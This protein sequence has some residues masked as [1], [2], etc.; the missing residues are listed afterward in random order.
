MRIAYVLT[1]MLVGCSASSTP[2]PSA[3][4]PTLVEA[5]PRYA[6]TRPRIVAHRGASREA[7]ENT[8]AAFRAAWALGVE[9][10]ELDVRV[11]RDGAVVVIHDATT[12]RIGGVDR[13]VADQTLAELRAMDAGAWRGPA[14]A[15]ERF[16][17]LAEALDTVPPGATMFVEIKTGAETAEAIAAAIRA[18]DP[19]RRGG[20]VAI[21][22]FDPAALAALAAA[23]GGGVPSYWDVDPPA[24]DLGLVLPYPL[25]V[26]AAAKQHGFTGLALDARAV[27]DAFVAATRAAGLQL[28]V[29]T[30]NDAA[31][32]A[33]WAERDVRFIETDDPRLARPTL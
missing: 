16:P 30:V 32:L 2:P 26:I 12:R 23:L 1:G 17:T 18:N 8:L 14:F 4:T 3:D 9:S 15:G 27:D 5:A 11:T 25:E 21:Q 28:D 20:H 19:A 29:W 31:E 6:I 13:A 24:D 33:A 22:G 7:P 10:C